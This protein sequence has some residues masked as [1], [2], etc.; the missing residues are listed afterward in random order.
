MKS[1]VGSLR[2]CHL[3][4]NVVWP[5]KHLARTPRPQTQ[6]VMLHPAKQPPSVISGE[7]CPAD[8]GPCRNRS[9]GKARRGS[10]GLAC[11]ATNKYAVEIKRNVGSEYDTGDLMSFQPRLRIVGGPIDV[12]AI[13]TESPEWLSQKQCTCPDVWCCSRSFSGVDWTFVVV[14]QL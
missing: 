13:K 4:L 2:S 11:L 7:L 5:T 14:P 1:S 12:L 6:N 3:I 8:L 10:Q 9:A